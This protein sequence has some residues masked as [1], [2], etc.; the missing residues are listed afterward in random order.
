MESKISKTFML[1]SESFLGREFQIFINIHGFLLQRIYRT[2]PFYAVDYCILFINIILC[3]YFNYCFI[4][5]TCLHKTFS[6]ILRYLL[7]CVNS[8]K[9]LGF[10]GNTGVR[11]KLT[12]LGRH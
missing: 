4:A 11:R 1:M 7:P 6:P 8:K 3:F 9:H 5:E 10:S 2:I 12:Y